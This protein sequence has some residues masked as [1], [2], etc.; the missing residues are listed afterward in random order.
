MINFVPLFTTARVLTATYKIATT[1]F[2]LFYLSRR[3]AA[4]RQAVCNDRRLP[5][6]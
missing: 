5:A 3:I 2:L 6:P 4:G 1:V